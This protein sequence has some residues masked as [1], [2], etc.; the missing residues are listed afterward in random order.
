MSA[1]FEDKPSNMPLK[2]FLVKKIAQ[3]MD[4]PEAVVDAVVMDQFKGITKALQ[5]CKS[6]EMTGFGKWI[7]MDSKAARLKE[8]LVKSL[9]HWE[10]TGEA[11]NF[12]TASTM[13]HLK[14]EINLIG[15]KLKQTNVIESE[16]NS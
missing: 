4:K 6:V 3:R 5:Q 9:V 1:A 11:P 16:A 2:E 7:F 12:P 14:R 13:D 10:Q 15:N 8:A